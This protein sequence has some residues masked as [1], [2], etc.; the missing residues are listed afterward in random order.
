MFDYSCPCQS[1]SKGK[2]SSK[3]HSIINSILIAAS[4]WQCR[5]PKAH[6]LSKKKQKLSF[7]MTRHMFVKRLGSVLFIRSRKDPVF[8]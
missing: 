8:N 5:Q 3:R 7:A 2:S 1:I 4:T 6:R